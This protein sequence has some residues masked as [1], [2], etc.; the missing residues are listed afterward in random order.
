VTTI[1]VYLAEDHET[2]RQGLKLLIDAQPDMQVVGEAGDGEVAVEQVCAL[3]PDI[4]VL[5]V[6]MPKLNGLAAARAIRARAPSTEVVALTR[7]AD[8]AYVKELLAAGAIGYVLKQSAS[9]ELL[10]AIRQAVRQQP[11]VDASLAGRAPSTLHGKAADRSIITERER[12]ALRL[13]AL[14]YS[15]KEIAAALTVAVKTV[16]VHKANG[17]RKLGLA[18]RVD[19]IRYAQLQGWLREPAEP[20]AEH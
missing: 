10:T 20:S 8:A 3:A 4:A 16:E 2:V 7:Y 15:N 5:D 13:M 17:M 18:G 19:V 1:R 12:E 14:G 11:Y 6:A 9:S